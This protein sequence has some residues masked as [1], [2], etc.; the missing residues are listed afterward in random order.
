[1][2]LKLLKNIKGNKSLKKN[3]I[4]DTIRE[5][6][7]GLWI[8][9]DN[10]GLIKLKKGEFEIYNIDYKIHYNEKNTKYPAGF[11]AIIINVFRDAI[12]SSP[13]YDTELEAQEWADRKLKRH[14]RIQ[15]KY[16]EKK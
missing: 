8:L 11:Y 6:K 10:G 1:M 7:G 3:R 2:E 14:K 16:N 12:T 13:L 4:I 5:I 9:G 15:D